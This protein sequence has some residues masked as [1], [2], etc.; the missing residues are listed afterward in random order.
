M[1][2]RIQDRFAVDRAKER[3]VTDPDIAPLIG[4]FVFTSVE[5]APETKDKH[6]LGGV[7]AVHP[8][9]EGPFKGV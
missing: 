3:P 4:V 2:Q 6:A 1:P 7:G 9:L 5:D 8:G